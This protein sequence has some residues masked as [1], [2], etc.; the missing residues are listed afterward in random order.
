MCPPK[1]VDGHSE[2]EQEDNLSS[3]DCSRPEVTTKYST[4]AGIANE[5]LQKVIDAC[6]PDAD[7][8]EICKL[9]DN[10]IDERCQKVYTKKEK[11]ETVRRGIAFPTCLSVNEIC[12]NFSPLMS[13][14][15]KLAE[16]DL[17]KIDLG[18]HIDGF[19]ATAGHTIVLCTSDVTGRKA[20]VVR[21]AWAAMEAALRTVVVGG[22]NEEVT[23]VMNK[24]VAEFQCN[25]VQGVLSHQL[26][27]H[28]IDG[29]KCIISKENIEEKV[30]HIEFQSNETYCI[31]VLVSTGEG[32]P[33]E[34]AFRTTVFKRDVEQNY[35]LKTAMARQFLRECTSR[36]P[37]LPFSARAIEDEKMTRLGI[38]ECCR[39]GLLQPYPVVTEKRG[40]F[41]AQFKVTVLLLPGGSKKIAGLPFSQEN[42][43]KSQFEIKDVEIKKLLASSANPK[44]KKKKAKQEAKTEEEESKTRSQD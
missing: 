28:V 39:H 26:K 25:M 30:D 16:G 1:D 21:A 19:I 23:K 22:N 24:C 20:D 31:N 14:S 41:V 37:S 17:V 11:G 2:P 40:E 34:S 38:S 6:T 8:A 9:G 3:P 5:V 43:I 7:I 42:V 13:E 10:L 4:A 15:Q 33:K 36:F 27:Q 32:K 44:K 12:G 29:V 35:S 18:V